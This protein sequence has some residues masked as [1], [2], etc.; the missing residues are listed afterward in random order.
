MPIYL[1]GRSA[2]EM[3]RTLRAA[4]K[5]SPQAHNV[6]RK[7]SIV[8][9]VHKRRQLKALSSEA[10]ELLQAIPQPYHVLAPSREC[11]RASQTLKPHIWSRPLP[12][13]TFVQLS[14]EVYL[15][16]PP[17]LLLQLATELEF[18]QVITTALEFCGIYTLFNPWSCEFESTDPSEKTYDFISGIPPITS[19]AKIGRFLQGC[20]DQR[21]HRE[22]E[23]I[24]QYVIDDSGS[25]MET[26]AYMLA[27]MPKRYGGYG[28]P[29]PQ[30]N[31]LVRVATSG[32]SR[33][34]RP[35]LYWEGRSVDVE[36]NSDLIHIAKS[37]YYKD[38]Q[39]QV[40]LVAAK[41]K[42]LP[43]TRNDIMN[44]SNFDAFMFGL[45]KVLG[46]RRY[47]F[48]KN[49]T[50]RRSALRAVVFNRREVT[51]EIR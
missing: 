38:A 45:E 23:K 17:F 15:S 2:L 25:P 10:Q 48:P 20:R 24:L 44:I 3:W 12:H 36:Y 9:A 18:A 51:A 27:C 49:W 41:V 5:E 13:G 7:H 11:Q 22:T 39:R 31:P 19:V 21:G 26:A 37:A 8:D 34:R 6:C 4:E 32:G 1:C 42:V 14:D 50:A 29:K 47:A 40:E 35:D 30:F 28:L 46:V 16:S 33:Y 43:L